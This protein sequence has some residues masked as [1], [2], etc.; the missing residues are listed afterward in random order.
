MP[1][2]ERHSTTSRPSSR[3]ATSCPAPRLSNQQ[4]QTISE[5]VGVVQTWWWG[6]LSRFILHHH[7]ENQHWTREARPSLSSPG[8]QSQEVRYAGMTK[9][10]RCFHGER[11]LD[12]AFFMT[13]GAAA[14]DSSRQ[15]TR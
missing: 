5:G 2:A 13:L 7:F 14:D 3:R 9:G 1:S 8:A 10:R 6:P 11:L 4:Q 15:T 12:K